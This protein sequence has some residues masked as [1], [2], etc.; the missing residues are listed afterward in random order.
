MVYSAKSVVLGWQ[1]QLFFLYG[2]LF[3]NLKMSV[4][5]SNYTIKEHDHNMLETMYTHDWYIMD[6]FK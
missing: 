2:C 6:C 5:C 4:K 3:I 1:A